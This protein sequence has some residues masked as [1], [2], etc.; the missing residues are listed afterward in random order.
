MK[1][2]KLESTT[3]YRYYINIY[4]GKKGPKLSIFDLKLYSDYNDAVNSA[5]SNWLSTQCIGWTT[6]MK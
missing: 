3:T 6:R 5:H 1:L 2:I 4:E